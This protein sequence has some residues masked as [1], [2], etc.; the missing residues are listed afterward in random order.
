MEKMYIK[1]RN[2]QCTVV[3]N[4]QATGVENERKREKEKEG[5]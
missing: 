3:D 2:F 5:T 4:G 1:E